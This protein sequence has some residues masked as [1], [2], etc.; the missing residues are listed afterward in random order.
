MKVCLARSPLSL[1]ISLL[2]PFCPHFCTLLSVVPAAPPSSAAAAANLRCARGAG[3]HGGPGQ[4]R[5]PPRAL[6][7]SLYLSDSLPIDTFSFFFRCCVFSSSSAVDLASSTRT[8]RLPVERGAAARCVAHSKRLREKAS[9]PHKAQNEAL[10]SASY[11]PEETNENQP[12]RARRV[13]ID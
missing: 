13:P 6:N 4:D 12:T 9:P 7:P 10:Q 3:Q 1:L 2:I 5:R 11:A 8:R